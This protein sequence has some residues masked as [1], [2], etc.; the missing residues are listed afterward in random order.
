MEG[1]DETTELCRPPDESFLK[2]LTFQTSFDLIKTNLLAMAEQRKEHS[3]TIL[4]V[5][6]LSTYFVRGKYNCTTV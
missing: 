4:R 6:L 2:A 1:A 3:D 5:Y